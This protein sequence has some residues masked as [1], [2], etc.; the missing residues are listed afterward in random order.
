MKVAL[1]GNMNNN[2]FSIMRY[3]RD[4]GV[5][6]HLFM[7]ENQY[8]HFKPEKDTYKIDKYR[9]YIHTLPVVE[10]VKGLLFL[11]KK[12]LKE[13]LNEYDFFIGSGFAPAIFYKID[14]T[15]DI[16]I[17]HDDGLEHTMNVPLTFGTALKKIA[18]EYVINLQVKGLQKNTTKII[19]S[20]VQEVTNNT[21]KRLGLTQKHI[22]KY[23]P[24]VYLEEGDNPKLKNIIDKM[25]DYDFIIFSH[26]RHTWQE[27]S[28]DG[29]LKED[30]GKGLD[31]L[32]IAYSN[33]IK[34]NPN[35]NPLLIFFEYGKDVKASK[36]L[37][38]ELKI[39]E[40]VLWLNLM[41]RKDILQLIGYADIVVDAISAT[42]WGGVGWEGLANGKILMQNIVQ[43]DEEYKKEMG[44]GLPFIMRAFTVEEVEKHLNNFVSNRQFYLDKA[45]SNKEWFDK[46]AGIGL[47]KEYKKIIEEIYK[48]RKIDR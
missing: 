13:I 2:F 43:S 8:D 11:D 19:T 48:K 7:Y 15:L 30:G 24:M 26:T 12:R 9:P 17:P 40:N 27:E 39:E 22:K 14:M 35:S 4:L 1:V 47:A 6:A 46:Y 20:A 16:F 32:M 36:E 44:H 34:K 29:S 31:K 5:D 45:S 33:F 41:P 28:L 25:K 38:K 42:M 10:K 23:V 18:R 21:L 37:I 3:L